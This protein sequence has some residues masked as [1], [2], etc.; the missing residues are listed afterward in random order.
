MYEFIPFD[1]YGNHDALY[2]ESLLLYEVLVPFTCPTIY[3]VETYA[4]LVSLI[5][6]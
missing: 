3:V 6:K 2:S 1:A 4:K 5:S